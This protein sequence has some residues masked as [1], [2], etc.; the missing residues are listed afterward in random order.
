MKLG[1]YDVNWR[2]VNHPIVI[3]GKVVF[4]GATYCVVA[5]GGDASVGVARCSAHDNFSRVVG[6]KV[7]LSDALVGFPKN[8]RTAV[9]ED[10]KK[11][12]SYV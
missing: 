4:R 12:V 11:E 9:W 3:D 5:G 8:V 7:S 6:R 10:Y 2:H 1:G